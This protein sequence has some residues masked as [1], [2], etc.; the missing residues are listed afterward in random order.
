MNKNYEATYI[1]NIQGK[2]EG[3]DEMI[4]VF[5]SAIEAMGGSVTGNQRVGSKP[6]ERVAGKLDTGY[7]L[8]LS[9][10]LDSAKMKEL[11]SQFVLDTRVYRQYYLVGKA[12]AQETSA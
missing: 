4:D 9:F 3:V 6:F 1:L 11:E 7:Y 8:G 2:E 12:K 5:K 10:E